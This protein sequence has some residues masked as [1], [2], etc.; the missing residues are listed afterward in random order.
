MH[1]SVKGANNNK[2]KHE[3]CSLR[4]K[5]ATHNI[6]IN[7]STIYMYAMFRS[8]CYLQFTNDII[9]IVVLKWL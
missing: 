3:I 8:P 7:V 2:G 4:C 1:A 5:C 9:G 6:H